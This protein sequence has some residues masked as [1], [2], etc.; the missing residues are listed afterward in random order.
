M[1]LYGCAPLLGLLVTFTSLGRGVLFPASSSG[2]GG[3][4]GEEKLSRSSSP[5]SAA[6]FKKILGAEK[7]LALPRAGAA[8]KAPDFAVQHQNQY[9][10]HVQLP[11]NG[12]GSMDAAICV[13]ARRF[14]TADF[15]RKF[16][17]KKFLALPRA[18][19]A[20]KAPDFAVQ[21]QNQYS[22]HVQLPGNG[23]GSMDEAICVRAR[24][25][26]GRF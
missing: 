12:F 25:S 5:L 20:E 7:I 17:A 10:T 8:G 11:G 18:G 19:A 22:T 15:E 2:Q 23:F 1:F 9:P 26:D 16:C 13:R 21:H 24:R 6:K 4:E 3:R 14:L